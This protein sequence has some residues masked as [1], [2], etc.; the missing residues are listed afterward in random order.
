MLAHTSSFSDLIEARNKLDLGIKLGRMEGPTAIFGESH[1]RTDCRSCLLPFTPI[2][3]T[4]VDLLL[5]PTGPTANDLTTIRP[6]LRARVDSAPS[7]QAPGVESPSTSV[8]EPYFARSA[9]RW[10]ATPTP[11]AVHTST[12]SPFS[13]I[14]A[15]SCG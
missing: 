14:S 10:H 7:T 1:D 2:A 8:A 11:Q 12:C 4:S 5:G 13:H 15:T 9:G 3:P 6:P